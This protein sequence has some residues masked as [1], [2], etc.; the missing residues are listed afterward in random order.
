MLSRRELLKRYGMGLMAMSMPGISFARAQTESRFVLIILRGAADGLAIGV[1]YGEPAYHSLRGEIALPSPGSADGL[2]KLDGLFGLHPSLVRVHQMYQQGE[3]TLLHAVATPYRQRSHFDAQDLLES[4]SDQSDGTRN[5][6]LNR[7]LAHLQTRHDKAAAI[8]MA[9]NLPLVLRGEQ[10]ATSWAP[11]RIPDPTDETLER[12]KSLYANDEF[13]SSRLKQALESQD[14]AGDMSKKRKRVN[15]SEAARKMMLAAAKFLNAEEGPRIAVL[16]SGGWDTHANQ[17]STKG[18]LANK[19]GG[20]DTA[21][22]E[23]QQAMGSTWKQTVVAVVTEFGRTA[24]VNGTRGTDHGT[25]SAALLLG[26]AVNGGRVVADWPGLKSSSLFEGRDLAP[27]TDLRSVFKTVLA[28]H[29]GVSVNKLDKDVFPGK[30][31]VPAID[32]LIRVQS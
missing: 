4:G 28:D 29:M 24:K 10:S 12:I 6:W 15:K 30:R 5:G 9:Q 8:A 19:L 31:A 18:S 14:I 27:T 21:L 23:F 32:N 16:E 17:G 22:G 1:P 11:S 20:L 2:L 26:G 7:A 25:A 13:F 3:A